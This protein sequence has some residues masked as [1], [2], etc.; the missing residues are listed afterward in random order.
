MSEVE[1][2]Y[3][4][5]ARDSGAERGNPVSDAL[6]QVGS[7]AVQ[8]LAVLII[9]FGTALPWLIVAGLLAWFLRRRLKRPERAGEE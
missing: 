2:S 6:R 1:I 5:Q 9:A 8:S 4:S 7:M 3:E